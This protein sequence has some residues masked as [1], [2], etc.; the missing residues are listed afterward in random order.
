MPYEPI[1]QAYADNQ[2]MNKRNE[3]IKAVVAEALAEQQRPHHSDAD[4]EVP[5]TIAAIPFSFGIEEADRQELRADFRH[6]RRWRKIVEQAQI[7]AFK[8][9]ITLICTGL[10]GAMS[11]GIMAMLSK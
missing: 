6:L 2:V 3:N 1:Q 8:V 9:V 10:V 7:C 5:R 11:V 4:D